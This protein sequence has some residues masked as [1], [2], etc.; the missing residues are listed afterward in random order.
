MA[1]TTV[2]VQIDTDLLEK[3]KPIFDEIGITVEDSIRLFF[4]ETVRLG[5]LPF[6][7]T[8]ENIEEAKKMCSGTGETT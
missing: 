4:E 7:Y 1:M 6:P 2:E 3:V 8:E 5:R